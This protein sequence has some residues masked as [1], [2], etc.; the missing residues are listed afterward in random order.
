MLLRSAVCLLTLLLLPS[1]ALAEKRLALVISNAAYP[2]EIGKLENPHKDSAVIAAALEAVGFEKG[3]TVVLKD[4]DQPTMRLAVAEF[5]ERIEKAGS[6][7]V[8]FLYYSGHGAADRT[9]RGENYLI[10]TGAKITLARQ[11][12]ILGV[13][14]SEITRSLERVPAKARFVV[15]DACRNVAFTK[16]LKDAMKGFVPERKLDGMIVAFA[17][18]PGDTAEDNNIYASALASILPTPGLRA[19]EVFKET[20]LR[21]ADLSKGRQIPWTEDGLLARFKFKEGVSQDQIEPA[22]WNTAKAAGTIAALQSYL[23]QYPDGPH[24][25]AAKTL[26]EQM[27]QEAGSRAGLEQREIELRKAEETKRLAE[28][29]RDQEAK[30]AEEA[31]RADEL[32]RAREDVRKAQEA[33][34]KAEAERTAALEAAGEARRVA[35]AAKASV[36]KAA[37][38]GAD[39]LRQIDAAE[40]ARSLQFELKRVG[41]FKGSVDGRY[42]NQTRD[43]LG[44][45]AKRAAV[46]INATTPTTETVKLIRGYDKRVCPLV[47][48]TNERPVGD[49]CVAVERPEAA[50]KNPST[51]GGKNCFEFNGRRF[52]Q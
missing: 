3:D 10:P 38:E 39:A 45:F 32:A 7:A 15:V 24:A 23:Q 19:E 31:K 34:R 13:S 47:C 11:L 52:C 6:D 37:A 21:V 35:D 5:I 51:V 17:T 43:A 36:A 29:K 50:Q 42:D 2:S 16:G 30:K 20:Q 4:V 44:A 1:V 9:D 25:S 41:C 14:L 49:Q 27:R 33:V 40:L 46:E 8:A 48:G 22:V 28:V 18:R 26:I 12:P